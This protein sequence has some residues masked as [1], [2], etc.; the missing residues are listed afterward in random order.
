MTNEEQEWRNFFTKGIETIAG[1]RHEIDRLR[2]ENRHLQWRIDELML[3]YCPDD[4]APEQ[5]AEYERN[6]V[7]SPDYNLQRT[8][9]DGESDV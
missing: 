6:Q 9:T 7:R 5:V 2:A 4:M 8:E 3:E 1:Q